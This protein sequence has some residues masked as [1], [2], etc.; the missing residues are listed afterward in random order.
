MS[1]LYALIHGR[2]GS[3]QLCP[4]DGRLSRDRVISVVEDFINR[5]RFVW[6]D[7]YITGY[8]VCT[9]KISNARV[10]YTIDR[11]A[12]S[13]WMRGS[14]EVWA[15]EWVTHVCTFPHTYNTVDEG[16]DV[17][18]QKTREGMIVGFICYAPTK[19]YFIV[20]KPFTEW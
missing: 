11:V 10:L 13:F 5:H 2:T 6:G 3:D 20:G 16:R 18:F 19:R 17:M 8:D 15:N 7:S 9:G 4:L 14:K 1:K 12:P